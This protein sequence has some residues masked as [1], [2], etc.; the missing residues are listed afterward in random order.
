MENLGGLKIF[1]RVADTL[2]FFEAGR[3][4]GYLAV[5]TFGPKGIFP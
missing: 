1:V 4:L 2:S 3:Q 5:T